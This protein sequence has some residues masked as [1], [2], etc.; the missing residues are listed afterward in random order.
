MFNNKFN[1]DGTIHFDVNEWTNTDPDEGQFCR[2]VNETTFEYIQIKDMSD[3]EH[4]KHLLETLNDK[5][6][7]KDWYQDEIDVNNYDSDQIGSYVSAYGGDEFLGD[8]EGAERNQ[9]I[10]ECI[11]E[12][13]LLCGDYD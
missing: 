10:A 9:L 5:T 7:I 2:K 12:T 11:F 3:K 13:D 6:Y 4:S 1:A 8:S